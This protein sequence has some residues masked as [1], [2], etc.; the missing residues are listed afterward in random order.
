MTTNRLKL[1]IQRAQ[2]SARKKKIA[3]LETQLKKATGVKSL[4]TDVDD[5]KGPK[6]KSTA[7]DKSKRNAP[8]TKGSKED[9][10]LDK[11]TGG[12]PVGYPNNGEVPGGLGKGN[13]KDTKVTKQKA[14]DDADKKRKSLTS[15]TPELKKTPK[16]KLSSADRKDWRKKKIAQLKQALL[17]QTPDAEM[18]TDE[19]APAD[20]QDITGKASKEQRVPAA[21][22]LQQSQK[23]VPMLTQNLQQANDMLED[24]VMG[25][26]LKK[27]KG[28]LVYLL[29]QIQTIT[30]SQIVP[31]GATIRKL[32][33]T[34]NPKQASSEKSASVVQSSK[35]IEKFD[36]EFSRSKHL[37]HQA[38]N[39]ISL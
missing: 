3:E 33:T 13:K 15:E 34:L 26:D 35:L 7:A 11:S 32:M 28:A 12:G 19:V 30:K 25:S 14:L 21:Q 31:L 36:N 22:V 27:I 39:R 6:A 17:G 37:M 4:S 8:K 2:A 1:R 24:A 16:P 10:K 5:G 23:L 9:A 18:D 20:M 29:T 38:V